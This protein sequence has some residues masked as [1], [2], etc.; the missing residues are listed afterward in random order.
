M[1]SVCLFHAFLLALPDFECLFYARIYKEEQQNILELLVMVRVFT[2]FV[3]TTN[4]FQVM[5]M[6][7]IN[8]RFFFLTIQYL[9]KGHG[10]L[11]ESQDVSPNDKLSLCVKQWLRVCESCFRHW[12]MLNFLSYF[13]LALLITL[14]FY[15]NC[16]IRNHT[17]SIVVFQ[18]PFFEDLF[19]CLLLF[20]AVPLLASVDNLLNV[21]LMV[22]MVFYLVLI[23]LCL[24]VYVY[25]SV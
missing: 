10:L 17:T 14:T 8:L 2:V 7:F 12:T 3:Q 1:C 6:S 25:V 4:L 20:T 9:T 5:W 11:K 16:W 13:E 15:F 21:L 23:S 22:L 24:C 19:C 18:N